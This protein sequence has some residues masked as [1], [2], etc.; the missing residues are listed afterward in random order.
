MA[1]GG[2][3]WRFFDR[4]LTFRLGF[5][6]GKLGGGFDFDFTIPGL[7]EIP[8]RLSLEGRLPYNDRDFD[9]DD[10]NEDVKPMVMRA[11]GSILLL[12]RIRIY[13]GANNLFDSRIGFTMGISFEYRD[14]DL[15]S[16]VGFLALGS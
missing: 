6:E 3:G 16:M 1:E 5:L 2:I 11:Y 10:I 12:D 7:P 8:I 13:F 15:R 14:E 4:A 9:D